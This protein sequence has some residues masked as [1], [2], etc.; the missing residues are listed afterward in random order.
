VF[1][2]VPAGFGSPDGGERLTTYDLQA[3][4]TSTIPGSEG[5]WTARYSHDGRFIA[6]VK[7]YGRTL[8]IYDV[9]RNQWRGLPVDHVENPTWSADDRYIYFMTEGGISRL[10]RVRVIDG[11]VEDLLDLER[12][13]L[14]A[15]WWFSLA[16]D[17]SPMFLR[18]LGLP[19]IYSFK[20]ETR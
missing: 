11:V 3:R 10:R 6:A 13:P 12:V 7:V 17:D 8:H 20:I 14:A 16:P 18:R 19:Q 1:G 4:K 9:A 15:Y 2:D 5:L